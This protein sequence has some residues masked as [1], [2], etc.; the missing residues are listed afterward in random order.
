[1]GSLKDLTIPVPAYENQ[2]GQGKFD[3]SDRYSIFDW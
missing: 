2:A 1:M 3:F